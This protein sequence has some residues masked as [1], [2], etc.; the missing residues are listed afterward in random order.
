MTDERYHQLMEGPDD[1]A[2]LTPEEMSQ[3]WHWCPEF[4]FLLINPE[5]TMEWEICQ[6][7]FKDIW[8]K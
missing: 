4:D 3:G 1:E 5:M 7:G 6:C 8:K 2:V